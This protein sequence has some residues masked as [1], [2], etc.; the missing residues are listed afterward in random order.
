[1]RVRVSKC[2]LGDRRRRRRERLRRRRWGDVGD[3]GKMD[4][5]RLFRLGFRVRDRVACCMLHVAC[6]I[7]VSVHEN[8]FGFD[9]TVNHP[10]GVEVIQREQKGRNDATCRQALT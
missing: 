7:P 10:P 4:W 3:G 9:V 2:G 8:I 6:C 5:G 1:M